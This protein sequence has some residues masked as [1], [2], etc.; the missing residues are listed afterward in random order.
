MKSK[1][2]EFSPIFLNEKRRIPFL[3]DLVSGEYLNHG[4]SL[5]ISKE[6]RFRVSPGV[7][8][9]GI[10][11][12]AHYVVR[13]YCLHLATGRTIHTRSGRGPTIERGGPGND[14]GDQ[15]GRDRTRRERRTVAKKPKARKMWS[16]EERR[17]DDGL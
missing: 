2:S 5:K 14:R 10:T 7:P 12:D 17:L 6:R 16:E 8:P 13:I 11:K 9:K 4:F 15:T 1:V 3:K